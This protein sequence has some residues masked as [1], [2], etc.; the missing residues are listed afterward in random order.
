[1]PYERSPVPRCQWRVF[2]GPDDEH[3]HE[4]GE[5][6]SVRW[7]YHAPSTLL[8][9]EQ[10]HVCREHDRAWLERVRGWTDA[11]VRPPGDG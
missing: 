8:P 6:A 2:A 1:M 10:T 9:D 7:T 4:C 5:P 3:G 11:F